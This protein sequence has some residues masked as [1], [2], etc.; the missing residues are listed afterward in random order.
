MVGELYF[1]HGKR[2]K[3]WNNIEMHK[4]VFT[5]HFLLERK[6]SS[7]VPYGFPYGPHVKCCFFFKSLCTHFYFAISRNGVPNT[8]SFFQQPFS[9]H[10]KIYW[11]YSA[12]ISLLPELESNLLRKQEEETEEG[13]ETV[14]IKRP[15]HREGP[16]FHCPIATYRQ[17]LIYNYIN[18]IY[19]WAHLW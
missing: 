8:L 5:R 11:E 1:L 3:K 16:N 10:K 6:R 13:H 18:F 12:M 14:K 17:N 15:S 19:F 9:I 7:Y 2:W 4:L